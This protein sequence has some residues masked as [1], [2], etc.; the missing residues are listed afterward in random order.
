MLRVLNLLSKD[1]F[2]ELGTANLKL[3][4]TVNPDKDISFF[5]TSVKLED[6]TYYT[7]Y[8]SKTRQA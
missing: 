4:C 8:E 5:K 6:N 3:S 2:S 7:Y 1:T